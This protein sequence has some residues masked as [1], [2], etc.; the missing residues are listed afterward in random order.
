MKNFSKICL[1]KWL[2]GVPV[3]F[4]HMMAHAQEGQTFEIL[5]YWHNEVCINATSGNTMSLSYHSLPANMAGLNNNSLWL[6]PAS[7]VPWRYPPEKKQILPATS[8][9]SGSYVLDGVSITIGTP[10]VACYS[11]DSTVQQICACAY[12]D[13]CS[14]ST[15]SEWLKIEL[16]SIAS[17]SLIFNYSTLPG[18][19]PET[20]GNWFGIWK[21][22][23][24]PYNSFASMGTG[25]VVGD[26]SSGA[27]SISNITLESKQ[28][29]TLIYFTGKDM[30]TAAAMIYFKVI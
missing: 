6:W 21:G 27:A 22:M 16:V 20:Y 12:L 7:Q 14:D 2:L 26:A 1:K 4:L 19:L 24:S 11:V 30:T 23:A 10:Y 5:S 8:G 3:F 13:A 17:N 28:V 9:E 25:H 29:Y 15:G 18:Y